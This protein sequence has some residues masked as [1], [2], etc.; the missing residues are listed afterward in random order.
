[1]ASMSG[2]NLELN[3]SLSIDE[4]TVE[5]FANLG[6]GSQIKPADGHACSECT[7][8]YKGKPGFIPQ[9][10]PAAVDD[11]MDVDMAHAPVKMIVM[12]GIVMGPTHC[13]FDGCTADLENSCGGSFCAYHNIE[14]GAR[15]RVRNC[16]SQIIIPTLV[17]KKHQGEWNKHN[18]T[19]NQQT[20]VSVRRMLQ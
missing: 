19:H 13:A 3:D 5:A 17:C 12:D 8:E 16:H 7:Q 15:C 10:D 1:I 4:V 14:F 9:Q 6:Q 11:D 20:M 2:F 18:Q